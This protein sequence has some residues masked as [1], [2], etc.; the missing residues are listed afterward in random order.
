[1]LPRYRD[2]F[3]AG[4]FRRLMEQGAWYANAHYGTANTSRRAATLFS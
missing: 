3:G 2:R 4:G 1:M